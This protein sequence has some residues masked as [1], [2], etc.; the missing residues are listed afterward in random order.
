MTASL[1]Q[2]LVHLDSTEGDAQRLA[3]ARHIASQNAAAVTAMYAVTP[4][5]LEFPFA[6]ETGP[7]MAKDLIE[8]DE[9]RLAKTRRAFD[10]AMEEPGPAASW[11]QSSDA[12]SVGAFAQ[13]ALFADLL[14]LGQRRPADEKFSTLPADF[15][16]SV[17]AASGRPAIVIPYVGCSLPLGQTIAIAW[18]EAPEAARAVTAS[19]PFLQRAKQVHILSW[20]SGS[21]PNIDGQVLDLDRYLAAHGVSATW[22]RGGD[23]PRE[24]GELLLSGA[25]DLEADLLVMGCYGHSRAREWVLGGASRSVLHSMTL[26]VLMSH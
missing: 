20:G 15:V 22:H 7:L 10:K 18:K 24:I 1:K 8:L 3:A 5:L 13:Q 2:L 16:E 4:A 21:A 19:L 11:S 23:E 25:F 9:E 6:P 12:P 26:P 14:V 17:L